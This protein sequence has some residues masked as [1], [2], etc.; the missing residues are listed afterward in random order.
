[1]KSEIIILKLNLVLFPTLLLRVR[2]KFDVVMQ[3]VPSS[4]LANIIHKYA[5]RFVLIGVP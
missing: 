5:E 2:Q 4:T 3:P 1:M